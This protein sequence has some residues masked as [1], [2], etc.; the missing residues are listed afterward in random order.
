MMLLELGLIKKG[1]SAGDA[2]CRDGQGLLIAAI[3]CN[4]VPD[5]FNQEVTR[6][7]Q[8]YLRLWSDY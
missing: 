8:G 5:S 6:T 2:V 3:A 1:F 4:C 7:Y